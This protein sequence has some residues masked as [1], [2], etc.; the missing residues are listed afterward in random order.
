MKSGLVGFIQAFIY[1]DTHDDQLFSGKDPL[2]FSYIIPSWKRTKKIITLKL[3]PRHN[4]NNPDANLGVLLIEFFQLYGWH[5]CYETTAILIRQG[6]KYVPKWE[7]NI[8]F[9]IY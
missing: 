3:H 4:A 8:S 9:Y 6:G 5:Y 2:K 7:V 1:F